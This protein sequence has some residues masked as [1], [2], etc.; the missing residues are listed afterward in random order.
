MDNKIYNT[1]VMMGVSKM[2]A[3][4]FTDAYECI[5][6]TINKAVQ[7][8]QIEQIMNTIIM[9]KTMK[10]WYDYF[11]DQA[12]DSKM[13]DEETGLRLAYVKKDLDLDNVSKI[14]VDCLLELILQEFYKKEYNLNS[15]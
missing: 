8:A 3:L 4:F 12:I 15:K 13:T 5:N 1:L 2:K 11:V 14:Q 7:K 10:E 9:D 6:R